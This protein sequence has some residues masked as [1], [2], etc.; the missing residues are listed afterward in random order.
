MAA[1]EETVARE[2]LAQARHLVDQPGAGTRGLWP[3]AAALLARQ[4]LEVSLRTYW[5]VVAPGT[6]EAS[7]RAQLLCLEG[8]MPA[9]A[10]R[11]AHLVWT[12]LS[13]ASHHHVYELAPTRDELVS[14]FQAVGAVVEQTERAWR[15]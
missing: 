15:K 13:R 5:S 11:Q 6:E 7:M 2:L 1:G 9:A 12:A 14:W 3:R 8:Y 4:S 10:A